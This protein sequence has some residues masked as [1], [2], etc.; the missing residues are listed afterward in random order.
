MINRVVQMSKKIHT[1][2]LEFK[3]STADL[4]LNSDKPISH[5]AKELGIASSTLCKWVKKHASKDK[6]HAKKL[7]PELDE[8]NSLRKELAQVKQ[9]RDILKKAMA[10]F[11]RD[12]L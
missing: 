6:L 1:Y 10:Y 7:S 2:T 12:S 3:Q 4:A 11:S 8:L 5:T 9:E